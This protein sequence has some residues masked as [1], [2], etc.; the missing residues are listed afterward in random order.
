MERYACHMVTHS[1]YTDSDCL[2]KNASKPSEVNDVQAIV[3][4]VSKCFNVS[5][6]EGDET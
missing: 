1:L 2:I 3:I 4:M 5:K 6:W